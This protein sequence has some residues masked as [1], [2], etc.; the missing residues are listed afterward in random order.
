MKRNLFLLVLLFPLSTL[1]AQT[2][3]DTDRLG[4]SRTSVNTAI[5]RTNSLVTH[6][7]D[8]YIAFYDGDGYMVLGKR[9]IG[10]NKWKTCVTQHKG[11]VSD[12]HNVISIMVDGKGY[13]H[14]AFDHHDNR[15]N[16]CRSVRPR[17][18]IL[19]DPEPMTELDE[20]LVTYPGFYRLPSG[21]I[22]F[23]YRSGASGRGNLVMNYYSTATRE[24]TQLHDVLIDGEDER[25]AYWQMY[26]DD[27]GTIHLSWVWRETWDVASN[28]DLCYAR[29]ED[30]GVT[31][32][33]TNGESYILP[34]SA[35]NAEYAWKIPQG[36][37]LINQTSMSAD[38]KGNPYI[39]TYWRDS[40]SDIP[41]YRLVWFDG[42]NWQQQQV[43]ERVTPFSLSGGGTKMI[44]ISRPQL[45]IEENRGRNVIY[46]LFRDAER[47]S[48]VSVAKKVLGAY[49]GWE[50]SD[51]TNFSVDAWEPSFDTELWRNKQKL[52]IY[53]QRSSQG[54]GEKT[55]N[56]ESQPVYVLEYEK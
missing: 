52:H 38:R 14:V 42:A 10:F 47:Q 29:S 18:L 4:Y 1:F 44:P 55:T 46:Y 43:S 9:K 51:L 36:R 11:N 34:I 26:V 25:S 37:E 3:I 30:G 12:A 8:Q 56:L 13:L 41:Q 39:A 21:D 31:W 2:L 48:R 23:A 15:L 17:S 28:H 35:D 49:S 5:F 33:K 24:W 40:E 7:G 27:H 22:L 32:K 19:D 54:D 20:E 6:Q 45:A 16:Y 53:V 50:I